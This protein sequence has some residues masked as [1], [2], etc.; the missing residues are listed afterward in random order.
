MPSAGTVSWRLAHAGQRADEADRKALACSG[1]ETARQI[2]TPQGFPVDWRPRGGR[3]IVVA[4]DRGAAAAGVFGCQAGVR[5]VFAFGGECVIGAPD[6]VFSE[7]GERGSLVVPVTPS[8][9]SMSLGLS[10]RSGSAP[11]ASGVLGELCCRWPSTR[12]RRRDCRRRSRR[13]AF[14]RRRVLRLIGAQFSALPARVGSP[15]FGA[16]DSRTVPTANS[17]QLRPVGRC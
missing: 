8:A 4:V 11:R 12:R 5:G 14:R 1:R 6:G 3:Q 7:G 10:I 17:R 16:Y 13:R 2:G 15:F 9:V